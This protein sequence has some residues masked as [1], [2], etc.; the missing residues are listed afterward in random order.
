VSTTDGE[1]TKPHIT[2]VINN[3]LIQYLF[4]NEREGGKCQHPRPR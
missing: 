3:D 4:N 1:N 2:V